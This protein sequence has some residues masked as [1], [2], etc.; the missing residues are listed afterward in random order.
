MTSTDARP[1]DWEAVEAALREAAGYWFSREFRQDHTWQPTVV[2]NEAWL[3]LFGK[4]MPPVEDEDHLRRLAARTVRRVL[5]DHARERGA[6]KRNHGLERITL[7]DVSA[8]GAPEP[9]DVVAVDE[10]L[11][12]FWK[13]YPKHAEVVELRLFGGYETDEIGRMLSMS[14]GTVRRYL[15]YFKSWLH[16]RLQ[17]E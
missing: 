16:K 12:W 14:P 13:V 6:Q 1:T 11:E 5:V 4:E 15:A 2:V 10:V 17:G 7:S 8:G 9:L 3:R